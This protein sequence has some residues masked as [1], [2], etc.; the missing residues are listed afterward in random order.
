MI[1]DQTEIDALLAEADGLQAESSTGTPAGGSGGGQKSANSAAS[2]PCVQRL[3][4]LRVPVIVQLSRRSMS[5][6]GVRDLSV[7]AIIEFDKSVEEQ[8]DLLVNDQ[9]I[10]HGNCVKVGENFGLRINEIRSRADRIR[11]CGS[12]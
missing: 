2:A 11:S 4:R 10:G 3:L 1:I 12:Q 8:L 9:I 7:G 5:I 6:H